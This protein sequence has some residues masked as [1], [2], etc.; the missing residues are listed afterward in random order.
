MYSCPLCGIVKAKVKVN[1][2]VEGQ[3]IM[4]WMTN[5]CVMALAAD[6][7][8][9]SPNCHPTHFGDIMIPI[10]GSQIIGGPSVQ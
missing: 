6:H 2:R 4:D 3:D 1:A 8:K 10:A 9:R 5:V 7:E